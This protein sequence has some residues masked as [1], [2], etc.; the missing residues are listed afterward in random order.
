MMYEYDTYVDARKAF[1][2]L[3]EPLQT[4]DGEW[5]LVKTDVLAGTMT[6]S[7][8]KETQA[9]LTTLPVARVKEILELNRAGKKVDQ[10]QHADAMPAVSNEPTYG[11]ESVEDSITRFD[12]AKRR[13]RGGRNNNRAERPQHASEGERP[14][15]DA[16]RQDQS[17]RRPHRDRPRNGQGVPRENA[18]HSSRNNEQPRGER[19][20]NGER[21]QGEQRQG[22]ERPN[23][24]ERR[25]DRNRHRNNRRPR[26]ENGPGGRNN[27]PEGN[28]G[29]GNGGEN[30]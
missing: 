7:S 24:G 29:A 30:R 2:R 21:S 18:E 14:Q 16:G 28:G 4:I 1:P 26:P 17:E 13:K 11:A 27:G 9:N 23:N 20:H 15:G 3:R 19:T 6:F 5:F 25:N 8:S 22:G 10:L 12:K